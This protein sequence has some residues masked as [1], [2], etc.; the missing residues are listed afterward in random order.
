MNKQIILDKIKIH[1]PD[2]LD[3]LKRVI[4]LCIQTKKSY[5]VGKTHFLTPDILDYVPLILSHFED[6][7]YTLEGGYA[8]SEY[9]RLLVYPDFMSE[10]SPSVS[11]L[12]ITYPVKYGEIGHRDVLGSLIG[13][14][15][16]R[17]V[18]GDILV[19]P[20][21]VQVLVLEEIAQY[22]CDQLMKVGRVAVSVT[23]GELK[24][25]EDYTPL[26][27]LIEVT[28]K[29]NRLDSIIARGFNISRAK[30]A[31]LIKRELVK[32]NHN[33]CNQVSKELNE[34]ALISVRGYGRMSIEGFNGLTKKDRRKLTIKKYI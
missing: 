31:E 27:D 23:I 5:E 10:I 22:V 20:G 34:D 21:K 32:V 11:L 12:E 17:D 15:I 26:Y 7:S 30:A 3:K 25:I 16:K 2:Q 9:Q 28:V 1:H 19:E 8:F 24:A 4:D 13:L 33:F 14:G 29:S 6:L 18:I